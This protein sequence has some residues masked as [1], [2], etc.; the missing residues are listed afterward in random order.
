MVPM[1]IGA[2][3]QF[4]QSS[5]I[6]V[7]VPVLVLV[8]II[9]LDQ[10]FL[11]VH[12]EF[13]HHGQTNIHSNMIVHFP[14]LFWVPCIYSKY[15]I[16]K[17]SQDHQVQNLTFYPKLGPMTNWTLFIN[18][19]AYL[20]IFLDIFIVFANSGLKKKK[21]IFVPWMY[22]GFLFSRL[23]VFKPSFLISRCID[24]LRLF[25]SMLQ[26]SKC[27]TIKLHTFSKNLGNL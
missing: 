3:C 15:Y 11:E 9:H 6:K 25:C 10:T 2:P 24:F 17:L 8:L 23:Q 27:G 14:N 7:K 12:I 22:M 21:I 26:S 13:C 4:T 18:K 20:V 19:F 16:F 1:Q 5:I